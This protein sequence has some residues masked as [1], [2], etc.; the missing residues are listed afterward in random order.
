MISDNFNPIALQI[1]KPAHMA[2]RIPSQPGD[3]LILRTDQSFT[4]HAVGQVSKDGQ[5][6]FHGQTNVKYV[7]DRAAA[8]AEAKARVVPGRRIIFRSI[9]TGHW[10]EI[11]G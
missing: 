2:E 3:V 1:S 10:S 11:S 7:S 8:V 5:Q 6:D 9:D 4:I